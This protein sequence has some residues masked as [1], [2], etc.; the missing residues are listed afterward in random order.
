M[1]R[2]SIEIQEL[3][4]I[5]PCTTLKCET[6]TPCTT[7]NASKG[8]IG[9]KDSKIIE[10]RYIDFTKDENFV[11]LQELFSKHIFTLF[12]YELIQFYENIYDKEIFS[13]DNFMNKYNFKEF[14]IRSYHSFLKDNLITTRENIHILEDLRESAKEVHFSY[15]LHKEES[16]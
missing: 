5:K 12:D 3:L 1:N 15:T 16:E 14:I 9:C 13:F 10:E 4:S 2:I 8:C 7:N 11:L 6:T